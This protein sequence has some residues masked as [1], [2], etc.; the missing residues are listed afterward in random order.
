M[1]HDS[2]HPILQSKYKVLTYF[3]IYNDVKVY[4]SSYQLIQD[5]KK[6]NILTSTLS[7]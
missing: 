4:L 6:Y 7:L 3:Y 5:F 2:G 1:K